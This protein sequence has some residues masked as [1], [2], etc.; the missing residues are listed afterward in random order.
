MRVARMKL[1]R[2]DK[3]MFR[4]LYSLNKRRYGEMRDM[5]IKERTNKTAYVYLIFDEKDKRRVIAWAISACKHQRSCPVGMFWVR[6]SHR[7][8][9]F[10]K[11]L[12]T[13][14]DLDSKRRCRKWYYYD[15]DYRSCEFF[16]H[17][18]RGKSIDTRR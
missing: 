8:Q 5:L 15:H 3:D 14:I 18:S 17:T 12:L 6:R 13:A 10:G 9:G 11:K 4:Q 1:S 2:V 16:S 7:R